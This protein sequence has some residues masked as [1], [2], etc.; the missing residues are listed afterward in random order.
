MNKLYSIILYVVSV[1]VKRNEILWYICVLCIKILIY[2]R[3]GDGV[4]F[5]RFGLESRTKLQGLCCVRR[6]SI[7]KTDFDCLGSLIGYIG[8]TNVIVSLKNVKNL[9]YF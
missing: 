9:L 7:S 8:N 6:I 4:Y 3:I 2:S 5:S 1:V